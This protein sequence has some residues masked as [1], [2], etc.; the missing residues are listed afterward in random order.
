MHG[1]PFGAD[2]DALLGSPSF[3]SR[4]RFSTPQFRLS[5][6]VH[7]SP[8]SPDHFFV[9]VSLSFPKHKTIH[10]YALIDSGATNSCVSLAFCDLYG[11]PRR[12]KNSPVPIRAVDDRPIASGYVTHDLLV[13]LRVRDHSE[14]LPLNVVSVSFPIIL[15]LDWLRRHN[16]TIDWARQQLALTCCGPGSTLPK[17]KGEENLTGTPATISSLGLGLRLQ[18]PKTAFHGGKNG[19]SVPDL[20]SSPSVNTP[21]HA[22]VQVSILSAT[23]APWYSPRTVSQVCRGQPVDTL[24]T[25][26]ILRPR[27]FPLGDARLGR[28]RDEQPSPFPA[29][30]PSGERRTGRG[31]TDANLDPQPPP[32]V[33]VKFINS[34]RFRK[35]ARNNETAALY[36][37]PKGTAGYAIASINLDA[38]RSPP[39]ERSPDTPPPEPPPPEPPPTDHL[40]SIPPKYHQF[41]RVFSPVEVDQLPPHREGFDATI[42]LEDGKPP[43]FGPLYHLSQEERAEVLKYVESNLDK[44][45]IRRSTSSAGAPILFVRKKSGELRL[46]VDYR[47]LNSI[48]RKN[49]YP[50]PL[51]NDLLD[52]V[53]G[54]KVFSTL[55]LKNAFNLIR[56]RDGDEWKTAF[57]MHLGLFEY[58]V[59]PFGL[60][61]APGTFQGYVQ[62][63]LRDLLDVVCVV[64]IDDILI[65]SRTQEEHDRHVALVLEQLQGAGLY[66]NPKK[67]AFD[68]SEVEYVGYVIRANG[69]RMDPKKLDTVSNWPTPTSIKDVQSFLSFTNF[70]R[71]FIDNYA[72]IVLPLNALTKKSNA[73]FNW[74]SDAHTAFEAL[75]SA[76]LSAPVLRNFDPALPSTLSTDAS[77]FAIASVLHQPDPAGYLHPVSYFSRKL[78]PAEINYGVHDKELLAIV[79]SFANMRAWLINTSTPIAVISDHKNLT[80]F[81]SSQTLN[82]RQARWAMFLTEYNFQLDYAPGLRNPADAPSRRVDFAPKKGDEVLA[83]NCR[84]LLTPYHTQ[85]LLPSRIH[86]V[87]GRTDGLFDHP[88]SAPSLKISAF[89]ALTVDGSEF[90]ERLRNAVHSDQEWRTAVQRGDQ[91]FRI[92]DGNIVYHDGRLYVPLPLRPDVLSS[93]HDSVLSGHPGQKRTLS[94]VQRDFSW[95]G[96]A[97]YVRNYVQACDMCGRIKAPR[98]KPFGLLRPLDIPDRPWRAITMDHVVKLPTSHGYDAI[99]VICDRLTRYAHF[100][101]CNES[102]SASELAWIF[103]DRVFRHHGM[104][105]SIVSDRGTTFVSAF[106]KEFTSLLQTHLNFSTAHHPQTDGLTER[107]NQTLET[108]LRAYVSAQQDDWVDYLP[109]AEFSYNNHTHSSTHA[110]PFYANLGYHPTFDPR[111]SVTS[112]VPAAADLAH[113]LARLHE[114]LR[115]HLREAQDAQSRYYNER[116]ATAPIYKPDQLVW[117]MRRHIKTTRP[118]DKLE[119]RRL[120]PFPVDHAVGDLAYR[121]RLPSYLSRLHPVFHVSLLEPYHDPSEF[122]PHARPVPFDIP[123][124]F[125]APTIQSI[126][127]TRKLGRRYEYLVH[128]L[129]LPST[130]DSWVPLSDIPSTSDELLERF[131]RRHPRAPRPPSSSRNVRRDAPT[132]AGSTAPAPAPSSVPHAHRR[133][134]SPHPPRQ[135][136]RLDYTPPS[137]TTL[138]SG[139]VAHPPRRPDE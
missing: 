112:P 11:L 103:L 25:H 127:D 5:S 77:D 8:S 4:S 75:R 46:C 74:T 72:K 134:P 132:D 128:W 98:H 108:Y 15:G 139:R 137:Q 52:C 101:P 106:W 53:Q 83:E 97:T 13:S 85:R 124:D 33:N 44:G 23:A 121:L 110:S 51:V 45:F 35:I 57:R 79:E 39:E 28:G 107:T 21:S 80:H 48:T 2:S 31:W 1:S 37:H 19:W 93:R 43:P 9:S 86:S 114:E 50:L 24:A 32:S 65:F 109:L 105:E 14:F 58:L 90:Q 62:D 40:G 118:S 27:L 60:T 71:H 34:S 42:D 38:D 41:A 20:Q 96:L 78:S 66:A 81:M 55:D 69:I 82:R 91:Q 113:R 18:A 61:N 7:S 138:R 59:M 47:G 49:R 76:I 36:Y 102:A 26:S 120:G 100:I 104:P 6:H 3:L 56:I 119:H 12:L 116:V 92:Q 115:A 136:P 10:T 73:E 94:L 29:Y 16:P 135:D 64:Y 111:V 123:N 130:E 88:P 126:L 129:E 95:P 89:T 70:Y 125:S 117:L 84:T 30:S 54:C 131:H 22:P 67:C 133:T 87:E 99:W 122:H 63:A 17:R 68:R